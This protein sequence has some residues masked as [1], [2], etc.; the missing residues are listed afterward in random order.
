MYIPLPPGARLSMVQFAIDNPSARTG[1]AI[2]Q[3]VADVNAALDEAEGNGT[4]VVGCMFFQD[5]DFAAMVLAPSENRAGEIVASDDPAADQ[6]EFLQRNENGVE[7][8]VVT[9]GRSVTPPEYP[10]EGLPTGDSGDI[11]PD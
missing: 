11:M 4:R 7:I 5:G 2:A 8:R 6:P 3:S 1:K 9:R 10:D